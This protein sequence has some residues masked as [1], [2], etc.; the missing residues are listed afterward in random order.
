MLTVNG[1]T[2]YVS[3]NETTKTIIVPYWS[4]QSTNIF[5]FFGIESVHGAPTVSLSL[6][7]NREGKE[8]VKGKPSRVLRSR[9]GSALVCVRRKVQHRELNSPSPRG[10]CSQLSS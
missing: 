4:E 9:I 2:Q 7:A 6:G 5:A 10:L 8:T 3:H 1:E